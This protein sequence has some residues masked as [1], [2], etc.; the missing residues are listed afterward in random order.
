MFVD[1]YHVASGKNDWGRICQKTGMSFAMYVQGKVVKAMASAITNA[2]AHGIAGYIA[3]GLSDQNW[4]TL[5]RN[6]Q[7]SNSGADVYALGTKLALAEVLPAESAT[8]GFRYGEDSSIVKNGFLPSYKDVPL[9]ELGNALIPNT[10][11]ATPE[12]VVPDNIIYFLPMGMHKP[13]HVVIEGNS[14]SIAQDP[15]RSADHTYTMA[16]DLRIGVDVVVG[17][18]FGAINLT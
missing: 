15:M 18:K 1:W 13:V 12:V 3:N 8:S 14:V 6:V 5:A 7:I 10:Q 17:T 2:S 4:M 11:N 9:I 16:V